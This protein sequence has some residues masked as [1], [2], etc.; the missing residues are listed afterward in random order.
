MF[1]LLHIEG[2]NWRINVQNISHYY[3][4]MMG[5]WLFAL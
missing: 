4:K 3:E 5:K 2:R 1:I